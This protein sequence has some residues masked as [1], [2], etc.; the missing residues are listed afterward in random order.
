MTPTLRILLPGRL[1]DGRLCTWTEISSLT[2][3]GEE[4]DGYTSWSRL[5]ELRPGVDSGSLPSAA[6]GKIDDITASQLKYALMAQELATRSWTWWASAEWS[7]EAQEIMRN[8]TITHHAPL[9]ELLEE[10]W[11]SEGFAGRAACGETTIE[12]PAYADSLLVTGPENVIERF[13]DT[14]LECHRV[15][16]RRHVPIWR[17]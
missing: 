9:L 11:V 7:D 17:D 10:H 12:G 13:A 8:G 1:P 14:T 3:Y 6:A 2:Q 15:S 16:R 4:I 5:V